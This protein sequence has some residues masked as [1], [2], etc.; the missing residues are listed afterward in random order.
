MLVI[1]IIIAYRVAG[2]FAAFLTA[3]AVLTFVFAVRRAF[4]PSAPGPY[5]V[6]LATLAILATAS[7]SIFPTTSFPVPLFRSLFQTLLGQHTAPHLA[8]QPWSGI[9][10]LCLL[11]TILIVLNAIWLRHPGTY[12]PAAADQS[13]PSSLDRHDF[14]VALQRYTTALR[15]A[16]DRIDRE[17]NWSDSE[18]APLE[19]QVDIERSKFPQPMLVRDLVRA[20]LKQARTSVFLVL[21]DPGSG[22]SVSLRRLCRLLASR[23]LATGVVPIYVNLRE[24][25][26][27][28]D[29]T[30][31]S[32]HSFVRTHLLHHLGRDG[33][34]LVDNFFDRLRSD[35]RLF[36]IFDSFDEMAPIL[37]SNERSAT[38]RTISHAFDMFCNSETQGCRAVLA[39]RLF[40]QP[41]DFK[42]CRVT[43]RPFTEHQIRRAMKHWLLGRGV[44]ADTYVHRLFAEAPH[45]VPLLRNPF[46]AELISQ[47][48]RIAGTLAPPADA[49]TVFDTYV[50]HRLRTD[51]AHLLS[52][53]VTVEQVR[54]AAATIAHAM[55]S[56]ATLGLEATER[57]VIAFLSDH[58]DDKAHAVIEALRYVRLARLGSS[59]ERRFS[60][61]HRR[62]AEFFVVES[63]RTRGTP[64][65]DAIPNDSRWRDCLVVYCGIASDHE[66]K[67]FASLCWSSIE[68]DLPGFSVDNADARRQGVHCLRFLCEAFRGDESSIAA[69]RGPLSKLMVSLLLDDDLL[70]AK[71]AAESLP[72]MT[73]GVRRHAIA[74]ALCTNH[75]WI[76]QTA[77][78][79]CRYMQSLGP[80]IVRSVHRYVARMP[81][82]E[83]INSYTDLRFSISISDS[84]CTIRRFMTID[85][86]MMSTAIGLG[87]VAGAYEALSDLPTGAVL[88]VVPFGILFGAIRIAK[89]RRAEEP[90][91]RSG[92]LSGLL[93]VIGWPILARDGM[94]A[95]WRGALILLATLILLGRFEDEAVRQPPIFRLSTDDHWR[96]NPPWWIIG[97]CV[98]L[99]VCTI[100]V[101]RWVVVLRV[102]RNPRRV[103]Q[104]CGVAILGVGI[105]VVVVLGL[106]VAAALQL[107][108][109]VP[110]EV[111]RGVS[112]YVVLSMGAIIAWINRQTVGE[113]WQAIRDETRVRKIGWQP[114][115]RWSDIE[116]ACAELR[117][118][119]G[120]VAY[121]EVIRRKKVVIAGDQALLS[122]GLLAD[123][124]LGEAVARLVE[125][126]A[127]LDM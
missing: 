119:G 6:F 120:R 87:I 29:P 66:R 24:W 12:P 122:K 95:L 20:I 5:H 1:G 60:F 114:N 63:F 32:I 9:A 4:I 68:R 16:L 106:A 42:A 50:S 15:H 41:I 77:F 33:A 110:D 84:L 59:G 75:L 115:M 18:L 103:Y 14:P 118:V 97:V 7:A 94:D 108:R 10:L 31:E 37:D 90:A 17:L 126:N 25:P 22:K 36:F 30:P 111:V 109:F 125:Q 62:F 76:R 123:P 88:S 65:G 86:V 100:P 53:G 98:G 57:Q 11:G 93:R 45:I 96:T 35:G 19:A 116:A 38:H 69:F 67:R 82:G 80:K 40:R 26:V 13:P 107:Q 121:L 70:A 44:N 21:G 54:N 27:S 101:Y 52:M 112:P 23:A 48:A 28:V 56:D 64:P 83:Y 99:L 2:P 46:T 71:I 81:V 85:M 127:G 39:S 49:F 117:T 102:M 55:Y 92:V 8:V 34:A 72:L 73:A 3:L 104:G 78:N 58:T 105:A 74:Y 79:S 113:W 124:R 61:V 51:A 91:P 47:Y 43:L 89:D